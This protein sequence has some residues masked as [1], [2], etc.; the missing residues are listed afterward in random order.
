MNINIDR[1]PQGLYERIREEV[2]FES[3]FDDGFDNFFGDEAAQEIEVQKRLRN[4][5]LNRIINN[6]KKI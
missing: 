1:E 6:V 2:F 3:F 4:A 5:K